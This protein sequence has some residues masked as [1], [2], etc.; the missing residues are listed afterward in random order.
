MGALRVVGEG[1]HA[2]EQGG[3]PVGQF[4]GPGFELGGELA[5]EVTFAGQVA[6]CL[7]AGDRFDAALPGADR[8][9]TGEGERADLR[10]V[11][12]VRAAAQLPGPLAADLDDPD[13]LVVGFR[14]TGQG[15]VGGA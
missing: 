2:R 11:R 3:D 10:G 12:D 1:L 7:D 14:R 8:R 15:T 4:L 9:V 13:G 6:E 5:D